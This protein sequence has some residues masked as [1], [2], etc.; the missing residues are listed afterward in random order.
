MLEIPKFDT[1]EEKLKFLVE[2]KESLIAQKCATIKYADG[3]GIKTTV[4]KGIPRATKT[5]NSTQSEDVVQ[6]KVVIN[7]TGIMDSHN[8]VHIKGLWNKSIKENKRIMHLQEHKSNSFQ[9]I[10][11]SG[12]DLDVSVKDYSWKELGFDAT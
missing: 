7:T 9:H 4:V 8:D 6:V 11:S 10:I 5:S 2:N 3:I 12:D 1:L